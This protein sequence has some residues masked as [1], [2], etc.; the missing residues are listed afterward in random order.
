MKRIQIA[1]RRTRRDREHDPQPVDPRDPDIL[2]AKRP[3]DASRSHPLPQ[4]RLAA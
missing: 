2:R 4:D 1:R 3:I